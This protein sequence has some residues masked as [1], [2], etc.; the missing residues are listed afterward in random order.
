M[1]QETT[2]ATFKSDVLDAEKTVI[3]DF[4]APWCGP[5]RML[6]PVLES[7]KE[8]VGDSAVVYKC[9]VDE[10]PQTAMTYGISGIPTIIIFK[11]GEAVQQLVGVQ[12]EN[13]YLNA[14]NNAN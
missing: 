4:W 14:V 6:S 11:N 7:V 2:D 10:N 13:V 5:C 8:K 12:P 9:N 3:V 1:A